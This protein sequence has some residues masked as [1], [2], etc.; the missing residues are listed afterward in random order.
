MR[1]LILI[2]TLVLVGCNSGQKVTSQQDLQLAQSNYDLIVSLQQETE[3]KPLIR[4]DWPSCTDTLIENSYKHPVAWTG[5]LFYHL[6]VNT[7][8]ELTLVT[9]SPLIELSNICFNRPTNQL[10]DHLDDAY[11]N[12]YVVSYP[13]MYYTFWSE[14]NHATHM[15]M[16]N[17]DIKRVEY[18]ISRK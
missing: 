12:N 5:Y 3:T 11:H 6:P 10:Q 13:E 1:I 7:L 15:N 14:S 8:K 17:Y 2:S 9:V 4:T 18:K 16:D